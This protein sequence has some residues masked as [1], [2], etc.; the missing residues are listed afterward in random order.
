VNAC[1][2]PNAEHSSPDSP[3][4]RL[5]PGKPI[6]MRACAGGRDPDSNLI[7]RSGRDYPRHGE[8]VKVGVDT[9]HLHLFGRPADSGSATE[10]RIFKIFI[11]N[12][13]WLDRPTSSVAPVAPRSAA[14]PGRSHQSHLRPLVIPDTR[15]LADRSP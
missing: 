11:P 3:A 9:D 5:P 13:P 14:P 15:I 8:V 12:G 4:S 7:V 1:F 10:A 6:S 2:G